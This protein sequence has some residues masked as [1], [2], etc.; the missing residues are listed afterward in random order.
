MRNTYAQLEASGVK[1]DGYEE[2]IER[3]R[4]KI[5]KSRQSQLQADAALGDGM[6]KKRDLNVEEIQVLQSVD[7]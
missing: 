4:A 5:G 1:G 3:T 7:R 2:G 6:E